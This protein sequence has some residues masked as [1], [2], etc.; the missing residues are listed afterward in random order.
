[1]LMINIFAG[2]CATHVIEQL[3]PRL[4]KFD[5]NDSDVDRIRDII[6]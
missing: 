2:D 3:Q 6:K 1:M 4:S 5:L